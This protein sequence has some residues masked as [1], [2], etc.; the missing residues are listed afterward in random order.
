MNYN[1]ED[2]D[3]SEINILMADLHSRSFSIQPDG[4][5]SPVFQDHEN[6]ENEEILISMPIEITEEHELYEDR[7]ASENLF[8]IYIFDQT[9]NSENNDNLG[10]RDI[11]DN[12]PQSDSE[13]SLSDPDDDSF[14]ITSVISDTDN[15]S[16][17]IT[18]VIP[19]VPNSTSL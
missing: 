14:S 13:L 1:Y 19:E 17:S 2:F 10:N 5:Y 9:E 16:L 8:S 15:D 7:I 18:S 3:Q 11:F 12:E 4:W 6:K